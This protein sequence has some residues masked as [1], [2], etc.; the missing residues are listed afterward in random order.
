MEKCY[1]SV[2]ENYI[3]KEDGQMQIL[4]NLFDSIEYLV[5]NHF[6]THIPCWYIRKIVYLMFGMKIAPKARICMGTIVI[7]ARA[8]EIYDRAVINEN[9]VLDGRGGLIIGSDASISMFTKIV[10]GSHSMESENF[11]YISKSITIGE[12][13]W[14]GTGATILANISRGSVIAAAAVVTHDTSENAFYAGV[15]AKFLGVR[16]QNLKEFSYKLAY[17]HFFR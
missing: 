6:V 14:I 10:T 16:S 7:K 4:F 5:L 11:S 2:F 3:K 13:T 15:P 1:K 12:N 17:P 9:C 8:I